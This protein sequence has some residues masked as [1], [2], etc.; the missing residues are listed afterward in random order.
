MGEVSRLYRVTAASLLA[1][2]MLNSGSPARADGGS[3]RLSDKPVPYHGDA[4][5]PALTP[6][7]L[8]LG[9]VFLRP[10]NIKPGF[11]LPTGAVWQPRF[12]VYGT[13]RSYVGTFDN[14]GS[15]S[16]PVRQQ[17]EWFNRV[18]IFGNLQLTGSERLLIGFQP[19]NRDTNFTGYRFEPDRVDKSFQNQLNAKVR[20][21]FFEGDFGQIFPRLDRDDT[22]AYDIGFSVGRQELSFQGGMLLNDNLDAIGITKNNIRFAGLGWLNNLRVTGL[23]AW[24]NVNRNSSTSPTG[25]NN[26]KDRNAHLYGLFTAMDTVFGNHFASTVDADLV[27]VDGNNNTSGN[28]WVAGIGATQ[29]IWLLNSTVRLLGSY[30]PGL[31]TPQSNDGTL[32]FSELSWTPFRTHNLLYGNLF[33]GNGHFTSAAR[34]PLAGGPLGR[35]GLMFAARGIG[36]YPAPLGNRAD[37]AIGAAVGYQMFFDDNRRQVVVELGGRHE[38]ASGPGLFNAAALGVRVQQALGRR[39]ILEVE[40]FGATR[41]SADNGYGLRV[42]LQVKL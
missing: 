28:L 17:A 14:G 27:F 25:N 18:D 32:L 3:S 11:T 22:K 37:N 23:A 5:L 34:D 8:E 13:V 7:I 2:A 19:L 42:E 41:R 20:T 30:A 12:W 16:R 15:P 39:Y 40:G 4:E 35:V 33:W 21:L 26:S 24:G 38:L 9:D 29:R 31:R 36:G 6:P 10:G 1:L